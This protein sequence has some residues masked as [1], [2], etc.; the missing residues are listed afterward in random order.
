MKQCL[1]SQATLILVLAFGALISRCSVQYGV[2]TRRR[3]ALN[4]KGDDDEALDMP[5]AYVGGMIG[6]SFVI[7]RPLLNIS[8][9]LFTTS[10]AL[11]RL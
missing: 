3:I 7:W 2:I 9:Q 1:L 11:H 8:Y 5:P 6:K 10:H 4:I